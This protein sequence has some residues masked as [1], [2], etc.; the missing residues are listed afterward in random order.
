LPKNIENDPVIL[1]SIMEEQN[2]TIMKQRSQEQAEAAANSSEMNSANQSP[3]ILR[4]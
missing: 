3:E 4:M 2:A 1:D